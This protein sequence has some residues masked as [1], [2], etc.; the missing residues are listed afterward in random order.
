MKNSFDIKRYFYYLK[1]IIT[2]LACS[3][4][5][6]FIHIYISNTGYYKKL[7][8]IHEANYIIVPN[9]I[10]MENLKSLQTA[11][12]SGFFF[13]LTVGACLT[14]LSFAAAMFW[15]KIL[16]RHRFFLAPILLFWFAC[17]YFAN[18]NGFSLLVSAH[19]IIVPAVVFTVS[20][21]WL[22]VR[23][24][25]NVPGKAIP[26][27][28]IHIICIAA[29]AFISTSRMNPATFSLVRDNILL[30][31]KGGIDLNNFYYSHTLYAAQVFKSLQQDMLRTCK[32]SASSNM[33][34]SKALK[35]ALLNRDY[36][37]VNTDIPCDLELQ[38]NNEF[39]K[40]NHRGKLIIKTTQNDFLKNPDKM[41]QMFSQKCDRYVFFRQFTYISLLLVSGL[42][43][44]LVLYIPFRIITL[45]FM[46]RYLKGFPGSL[47]AVICCFIAGAMSLYLWH[48]ERAENFKNENLE[49]ALKSDKLE[50]RVA[51]LK[52]IHRRKMDVGKIGIPSQMPGS[53]VILERYWLAK[54]LYSAKSASSY[55]VNLALLD[56]P[57]INVSYIAFD[58]LGHKKNQRAA[59]EILE[60]IPTLKKW[61]VQLYAYK[62]L[63]RLKWRQTGLR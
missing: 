42:F 16:S 20:L 52:Y 21:K 57:Q 22:P 41:L 29:L 28:F 48:P 18:A 31:N 55:D 26:R 61:Y 38:S 34:V 33:P 49:Q 17:L 43:C 40:M 53:P 19:F 44:Y 60:R 58:A 39:I 2:G 32:I 56:D 15:T 50:T 1:I 47:T 54:T 30:S 23:A 46:G 24:K 51:A 11:F 10:V 63:R 37:I 36:L 59:R 27:I 14:I 5:I 12:W 7:S 8:A 13:T 4:I 45:F 9:L 62:S 3:H 25:S 35:Q 6:S